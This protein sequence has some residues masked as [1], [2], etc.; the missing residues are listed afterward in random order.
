MNA[1]K[2]VCCLV[3]EGYADWEP[4][5][6]LA[7]LRRQDER[8]RPDGHEVKTIGYD[9]SPVRSMGGMRILPDASLADLRAGDIRMLIVPG[10]DNRA[11]GDYPVAALETKLHELERG[12]VAIAA[13]CGATVACARA[14]LFAGRAHTSN[15]R[16]WLAKVAPNYAGAELYREQLA[17]RDR[18]LITAR[19]TASTE[20]ACEILAELEIM[21][22]DRRAAWF[23]LF[24]L[25]MLPPDVDQAAFFKNQ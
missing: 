23:Y 6:A 11:A 12:G 14:G 24:K 17:V 7:M 1:K 9:M 25:G 10:G 21:P 3:F 15:D 4:A 19:G 16:A 18:G 20:F 5:L 2:P 22:H 13:I 8:R